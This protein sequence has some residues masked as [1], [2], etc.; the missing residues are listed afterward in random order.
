MPLRLNCLLVAS[1]YNLYLILLVWNSHLR[2]VF[3]SLFVDAFDAEK[4]CCN[5]GLEQSVDF[6]VNFFDIID[7]EAENIISTEFRRLQH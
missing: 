4:R 5:I 3:L 2:D 6:C 7:F 1:L